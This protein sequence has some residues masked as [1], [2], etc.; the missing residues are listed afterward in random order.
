MSVKLDVE[1]KRRGTRFK[2]FPQPAFLE[3]FKEPEIVWV[4]PRAGTVALGPTDDR[5]YVVD[6]INKWRSYGRKR[7][8]Y[9]PYLYLPPWDGAEHPP[10]EPDAFGHFDYL[11]V[12]TRAFEAAHLYGTIRWVLDIWEDYFERR[13]EWHFREDYERLE[14]ILLL[15]WDNAQSGYGFIEVGYWTTDEGESQPYSLHFDVLAHELGHSIIYAEIGTPTEATRVGE[16]FGFHESAADLV[17]LVSVL[18]FDSVVDHLLKTSRGNLYTYNELNRIG[19]LSEN[20]QIRLAS[21]DSKVSDFSEGWTDEHE[22]SQPLTGAIFDVFVDVFQQGLLERGL[23]S[24]Y[25]ADLSGRI[26]D[27]PV[28]ENEIQS[29]FDEAYQDHH[30]EFKHALWEARDYMGTGLARTWSQLSPDYLRYDDV[31]ATLLSVDRGLTGGKY[32]ETILESLVWREI[33]SAVVGPRLTPASSDAHSARMIMPERLPQP[34]N[35]SYRER[36]EVA[37]SGGLSRD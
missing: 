4:S 17:A 3:P 23:I 5:M 10:V 15:D 24:E 2:L 25:L 21:N 8:A 20:E 31:G 34:A 22:L 26:S 12:G 11:D 1:R 28:D 18:H 6:P 27:E 37:R 33:G 30:Q 32:Q 19:E 13:I 36:M 14:L 35:L 7:G 29:L 16:Y 9:G